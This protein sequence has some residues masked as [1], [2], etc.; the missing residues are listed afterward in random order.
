[1]KNRGEPVAELRHETVCLLHEPVRL[2]NSLRIIN[3]R[4]V[5]CLGIGWAAEVPN[6]GFNR[7]VGR[8]RLLDGVAQEPDNAEVLLSQKTADYLGRDPNLAQFLQVMRY[9]LRPK[10]AAVSSV[11]DYPVH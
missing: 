1:M 7:E 6:P 11:V 8:D 2:I 5:P 3:N 4:G 9:H 10:V